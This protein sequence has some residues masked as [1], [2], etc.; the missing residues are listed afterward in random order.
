[1]FCFTTPAAPAV[2]S[3]TLA[4]GLL[5]LLP[6]AAAQDKSLEPVIVTA[7]RTPQVA[8]DVLSDTV[9]ITAEEIAR[10]GDQSLVDLLQRQRGVEVTRNGGRGANASVFIR[11]ADNRQNIVLIDGVRVG[12]ATSGAANWSVIPLAQIERIEIAY[13]PMSSLYGADAVGGVVQIF[14]RRGEDGVRASLSAAAGSHDTRILDAGVSGRSGRLRFS[15]AASHEESEGFSAKKPGVLSGYNPDKDGHRKDSGNGS[16]GFD[17]APGHEL[18]LS[19]LHSRMNMQYDNSA[20]RDDR[21]LQHVESHA[22]NL[23]NRISANWTSRAQVARSYDKTTNYTTTISHFNTRQTL[24]S[25]QSDLNFGT[26]DLLQFVLE[27]R[28]EE[29]DSSTAAL[30]RTR[31]TNA[32]AVAYQL[33]RGAHLASI[34][35]RRDDNSQFGGFTTGSVGYGYRITPSLRASG[36][37][38]TSFR[39]P[40][41]NELYAMDGAF[42][43]GVAT[44]RPERGR[45]AEAGLVYES[46]DTRLSATYFHNRIADLIVRTRPCPLPGYSPTLGCPV[47]VNLAVLKGLS[48]GGSTR[49]GNFVYRASVDFQDPT[50][51]TNGR[52]LPR[53]AHAHGKLAL[54]Y[55]TGGFVAGVESVLS[56]NRFDNDANTQRLSGYGLF[57][58]HTSYDFA[59][60]WTVFGRW[61][62]VFD[63]DY[64]LARGY[65][66]EGSSVFVGLRY[67]MK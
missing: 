29:V 56:S 26:A 52:R 34:S 39:A 59:P 11:G 63:K 58:L 36:A 9:V 65:A 66:T 14:T 55:D 16:L 35:A 48:L 27:R 17:L 50:D 18:D 45:N 37:A 54:E 5:S 2:R 33:K 44:N 46:G 42:K 1:M 47:N 13:G 41:F 6:A 28:E 10:S 43:F 8:A 31:S 4:L 62:N 64:E 57:N 21:Q 67:A 61:N 38:G 19:F 3:L 23:R 32:A 20:L 30:N 53:R 22:I 25:W 51:R 12:S 24:Y 15:F 49:A 40:T 7:S 60:G